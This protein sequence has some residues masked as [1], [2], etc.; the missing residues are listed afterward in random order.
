MNG[1]TPRDR[2]SSAAAVLAVVL[3]LLGLTIGP[4][5]LLRADAA[6]LRLGNVQLQ[7][8]AAFLYWTVGAVLMVA[9]FLA[10]MTIPGD[11]FE[12]WW[13]DIAAR[14]MAIS[15]GA[16]RIG[17]AIAV[18]SACAFLAWYAFDRGATTA[19]GIAQVWHARILLGGRLSLP[20]DP[21]PE[22]FAI[23]NVI[24][25][26]HWM[27]QFP[28]G[29]PA[30]QAIGLL[31]GATW[32]INP[33]LTALM[34][35]LVYRIARTVFG[36]A[37]GR[38]AAAVF[39]TSPMVLLMGGTHMNHP[40]TA[41]C[42]LIAFSALASWIAAD[43][44]RRLHRSALYIGGSIGLATMI[45]PLD[46]VLAGI[47]LALVMLAFAARDRQRARSLLGAIGAGAI[48]LTLL[49]IVNWRTTGSP[50]LFGYEVLWGPNHSLGLHDDPTGH[51]H[52]AGRALL[53][54][55]KYAVQVNWVATAWPI[56]VFLVLAIGV[57]FAARHSRWD[58]I[59]LSYFCA[60]L[61]AYAFYWHDGQFVGPRFLFTAVP[62]LLMLAARAP[63]L[64]TERL[65]ARTVWR[66]IAIVTIP[67]CVAVTWLRP[68][69]PFG[70]QSLAREFRDTRGRFKVDPPLLVRSGV[71]RNA[72]VFIQEGASA[73]L[74]HRLWGLGVSRADAGRLIEEADGCS[75]FE[76]VQ[77][78][79]RQ[80][81]T[82]GRVLRLR[83]RAKPF[84][85][86]SANLRVADANLRITDTMSL[87]PTCL[88]EIRHDARVKNTVAYGPMLLLNRF[89]RAGRIAG[90]A[91]YVMDL[92]DRNEVLRQRFGNRTWYRYEIPR[93]R[94]DTVPVLV[95]Y[96]TAP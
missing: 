85:Q 42:V 11:W 50:L 45:R 95:P 79:E 70:A 75:L 52:G 39:A 68:M 87:T 31:V 91:I 63:F 28:I 5:L 1:E 14:V 65:A 8:Y 12:R 54:A 41:L 32:L 84:I 26:P 94:T 74:A 56:P 23:D 33:L 71:V 73:R 30:V 22:F 49:L 35:L 53:L 21:N 81:D 6:S 64:V 67:V 43:T 57:F 89:D 66:R 77:M 59:L 15:D 16:F 72:L 44:S 37:T 10:L 24:D 36:E 80:P 4:L 34:A 69:Q 90:D 47:L 92:R 48:P 86:S 55:A 61:A 58:V 38:A 88:A 17:L 3:L 7:L 27:S 62:G 93:D 46:G 96:G 25:R 83:S 40:A 51:P 19:D 78:E 82:T 76:A 9:P 18:F 29:G 60:Q 13:N 20:P 2:P